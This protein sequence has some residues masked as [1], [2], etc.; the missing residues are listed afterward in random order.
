MHTQIELRFKDGTKTTLVRNML[1]TEGLFF[2]KYYVHVSTRNSIFRVYEAGQVPDITEAARIEYVFRKSTDKLL[3]GN[4][5]L[6]FDEIECN[7]N[8]KMSDLV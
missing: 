1:P 2:F 8:F 4:R 6:S 3:C 5:F 7:R